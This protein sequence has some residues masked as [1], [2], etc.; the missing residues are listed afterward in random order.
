M[1]TKSFSPR[2]HLSAGSALKVCPFEP[3]LPIAPCLSSPVSFRHKSP[4]PTFR[5]QAAE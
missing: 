5:G 4:R 3:M 1:N 2:S